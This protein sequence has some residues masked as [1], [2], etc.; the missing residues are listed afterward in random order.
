MATAEVV[1]ILS[2][3]SEEAENRKAEAKKHWSAITKAG[4]LVSVNSLRIGYHAYALKKDSLFGILGFENEKQAQEASGVG[5]S[6]WFAMIRLAEQFNTVTEGLFCE[7]KQAN[8]KALADLPESKRLTEY[9]LR[10]AATDSMDTFAALIEAELDGHAKASDGKERTVSYSVK[11]P[12]SR[13]N[14]VQS[15]LLEYAKTVGVDGDESRALELLVAEKTGTPSLIGTITSA[16]QK[17]KQVK[18]WCESGLSS[19]EVLAKVV[20][21]NEEMIL[22]FAAALNGVQNLEKE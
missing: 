12:K 21:L 1:S 9:W 19:D 11:M 16:V 5:D 2:P 14:S 4:G 6:T 15:G 13:R 20:V 10:R 22:E 7:M 17:L 3:V 18:E 8:A